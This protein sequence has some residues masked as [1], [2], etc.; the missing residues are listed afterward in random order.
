M[1]AILQIARTEILEH[2][3]QPAM[4]FIL[5][6]N[7]VLW[8]GAFGAL[9]LLLETISRQPETLELLRQQMDVFGVQLDAFLQLATSSYGSL[10]FTNLPLFVAIMSGTSIIHDRTC[11]TMPF[12]M[13]APITRRQLITGKLVGAMAI[14]LLFHVLF[15]G[16]SSL[17]LGRLEVLAPFAHKFGASPAWWLAFL[18][19]APASAFFVGALGTVISALSRDVRTSMQYTSFFIGLLS[20]GI[21]F[22]LVDGISQGIWL[23]IAFAAAC[24]V[25]AAF[26]LLV[27]ARLISRDVAPS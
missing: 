19:G 15:V 10:L 18:V 12:L 24:L 4:L 14:P 9:F 6:A 5:A 23:Q 25:A 16:A 7:Y 3:R 21:G 27:G 2:R 1:K 20:L 26:T 17:V 13:L 22:A 11:G 8:I